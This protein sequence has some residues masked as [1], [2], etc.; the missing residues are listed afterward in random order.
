M[1][2]EISMELLTRIDA[3]KLSERNQQW[4]KAM[5]AYG[6]KLFA[7]RERWT[8]ASWRETEGEDI[9][10]RRAKLFKNIVENVEIRIHDFDLIAG[11]LTPGVIGCSTSFDV[12]GDYIPD[13]WKDTAEVH[14]TMDASV[15][16]DP[17]SIEI[18]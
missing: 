12:C 10:I 7:D 16:L 18:L 11:R 1:M 14:I 6:W 4:K 5:K 8:V 15:G 9:Q 13:I 17:G 2:A 3:L